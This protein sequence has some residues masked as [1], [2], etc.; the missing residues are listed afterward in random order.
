E[1]RDI[2]AE[3]AEDRSELDADRAAA[4]HSDRLRNFLQM[5]RLVTRDDA[6]A[7]DRNAWYAPRL[8]TGRDDDVP[9]RVQRLRLTVVNIDA[10]VANEPRGSLNAFDLFFLEEEFDA[11]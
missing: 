9:S 7:V 6:L 2:A 11:L 5:D 4:H 3:A 1:D 10:P 8:R